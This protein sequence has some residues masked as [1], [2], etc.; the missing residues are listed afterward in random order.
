[1]IVL[2]TL[3][4]MW[5][6]MTVMN[7]VLIPHLKAV[8]TLSYAQSL[9]IQFCFFGAYGIGS[10]VYFLYSR[11]GTDPILKLGYKRASMA[12]LLVSAAGAAM[13]VPATY[14]QVYEAYLFALFVL[15]L[16]FTLLQIAANPFV[17]LVGA[18]ENASGRLNLAQGF[19]SLGTT[20]APVIGGALIF[21]FFA[22]DQAVRWP[23][24][25]FAIL[26]VAQALWL[27]L[28]PLPEPAAIH[29][30]NTAVDA[31]RSPR[32]RRGM[33]AIFFYVGAEVAIGSLLISFIGLPQ[34]AGLPPEK[35]DSFLSLYWGGAMT[36]RFLGSISLS[37]KG[38]GTQRTLW[39]LLVA[40]A[41][42]VIIW[43]VNSNDG[44]ITLEEMASFLLYTLVNVIV[45]RIAGKRVGMAMG[46]FAI[47]A[48]ILVIGA[49]IQQGEFAMWSLIAVGLF[50]SILWS[51]IFSLSIAGLKEATGQG[52]SLLVMMIIGGAII[53][54]L[55]GTI[56]DM[57]GGENGL[58]LSFLLPAFCYIYLAWFGIFG[59]RNATLQT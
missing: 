48:F 3:F 50:N 15:G 19:N 11:G 16:G 44:V 9:L 26:L 57:I 52:S 22:G 30:E 23:Y 29:Q 20:L 12:G 54:L 31:W 18:P 4:F 39:M 42:A 33:L 5:G 13:F 43:A 40:L 34:I 6:F 1:M 10:F 56:A 36:G 45:L 35:A 51:N 14:L 53:P 46:L 25:F 58:Q 24:L 7:D 27:W 49:V 55:Q 28:T 38:S 41:M 21:Q 47:A 2:T 8:F 32:L 17:A 59:S 37:G